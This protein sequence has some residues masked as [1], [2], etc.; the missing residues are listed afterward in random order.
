MCIYICICIYAYMCIDVR[1]LY[2]YIYVWMY[3]ICVDVCLSYKCNS[4]YKSIND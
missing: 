3:K 2:S 4:G 1:S